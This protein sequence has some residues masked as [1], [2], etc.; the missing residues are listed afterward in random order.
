MHRVQLTTPAM[1]IFPLAVYC[2]AVALA[3]WLATSTRRSLVVDVLITTAISAIGCAIFQ[4]A[5]VVLNEAPGPFI[6]VA[7]ITQLL[8]GTLIGGVII[9][10]RRWI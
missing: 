4:L 6:L 9:L 8:I 5:N 3:D 7:V 2:A 1:S 10:L